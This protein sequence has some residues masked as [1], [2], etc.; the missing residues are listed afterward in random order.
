MQ[1]YV[2]DISKQF[3]LS[4]HT[5]HCKAC[6]GPGSVLW[7]PPRSFPHLLRVYLKQ[8]SLKP[9][10]HLATMSQDIVLHKICIVYLI[11]NGRPATCNFCIAT[12][13]N[14]D[15]MSQDIPNTFAIHMF[16]YLVATCILG[17]TTLFPRLRCRESLAWRP[18][19]CC[20]GLAGL[21]VESYVGTTWCPT[22]R[23]HTALE[24]YRWNW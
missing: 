7:D 19:I 24:Q 10:P 23:Y 12:F 13:P 21:N 22:F 8:C 5:P 6:S 20:Y 17:L 14:R 4:K 9:S 3:I 16:C 2:Y 18:L 15:T 11:L 1:T